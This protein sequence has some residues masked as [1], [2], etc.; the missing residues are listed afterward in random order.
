[1]YPMEY[2]LFFLFVLGLSIQLINYIIESRVCGFELSP[3]RATQAGRPCFFFGGYYPPLVA[4][5][6][7][8]AMV[9]I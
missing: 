4:I 2:I 6:S 8:N 3:L 5:Y 7:R 1:M 9:Q